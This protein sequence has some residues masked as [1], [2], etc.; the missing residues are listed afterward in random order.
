VSLLRETGIDNEQAFA[1]TIEISILW[2]TE[3][4]TVL[5]HRKKK[6]I[7]MLPSIYIISST[8]MFYFCKIYVV[9]GLHLNQLR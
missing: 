6:T 1:S 3:K 2:E 8:W 5:K 4:I 7:Y 9:P